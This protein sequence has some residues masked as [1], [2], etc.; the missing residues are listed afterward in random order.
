MD[1]KISTNAQLRSRST[2]LDK[3]T[4]TQQGQETSKD[5]SDLSIQIKK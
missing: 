3:K 5:K 2:A 1:K 4:S